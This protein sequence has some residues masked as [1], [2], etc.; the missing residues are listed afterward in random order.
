M[1][2]LE[3]L[4]PEKF[5]QVRELVR[6]TFPDKRCPI[7]DDVVNRFVAGLPEEARLALCG[8]EIAVGEI[9]GVDLD[10]SPAVVCYYDVFAIHERIGGPAAHAFEGHLQ[11]V[12]VQL[13]KSEPTDIPTGI[14]MVYAGDHKLYTVDQLNAKYQK[15]LGWEISR[16]ELVTPARYPAHL[17][18]RFSAVAV[19]VLYDAKG[20]ARAYVLEAGMA[21][22]EPM[23]CFLAENRET[24][25]LTPTWYEPT[26]FSS[27]KN[28][29]LGSVAFEQTP[30]WSDELA[31]LDVDVRSERN[32]PAHMTIRAS[33]SRLADAPDVIVPAQLTALAG[34]RVAAIADAM[35]K[36]DVV[37]GILAH[38]GR[39][40]PWIRE[41]GQKRAFTPGTNPTPR[42]PQ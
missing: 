36:S 10:E 7:T 41:P 4:G 6:K 30:T 34:L 18:S 37:M 32:G 22:G 14:G 29:Y 1:S 17:G 19:F 33:F 20:K 38:F 16:C 24:P 11:M 26:P 12:R 2:V 39:E 13:P 25:I 40:L 21:T 31:T 5:E 42:G 27:E 8:V 28:W 15:A 9:L 23:V 3:V 35:G